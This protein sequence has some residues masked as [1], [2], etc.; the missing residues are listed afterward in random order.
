[1]RRFSIRTARGPSVRPFA[2]GLRD[3]CTNSVLCLVVA[4]ILPASGHD[5]PTIAGDLAK[6]QGTWETKTGPK[7]DQPLR[8]TIEEERN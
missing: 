5:S 6:L 1:M 3:G 7:K 4:L 8:M 2:K